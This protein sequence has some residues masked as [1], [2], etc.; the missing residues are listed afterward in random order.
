MRIVEEIYKKKCKLK[1][2]SSVTCHVS[3][4]CVKCQVFYVTCHLSL[5]PTAT[6][7]PVLLPPLHKLGWFTKTEPKSQKQLKNPKKMIHAFQKK[8]QLVVRQLKQ[9]SPVHWEKWFPEGGDIPHTAD[10]HCNLKP[11]SAYGPI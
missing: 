6:H 1:K 10:A 11:F 3:C 5:K 2:N 7:P 8:N 4:F 9:R